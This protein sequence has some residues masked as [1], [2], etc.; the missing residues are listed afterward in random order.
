MKV[1]LSARHGNPEVWIVDLETDAIRVHRHP[2]GETFG[3]VVSARP[4]ETLSSATLPDLG[5]AVRDVLGT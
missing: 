4:R 2:A 3:P 5:I 1:P